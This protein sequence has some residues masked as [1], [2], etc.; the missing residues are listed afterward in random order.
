MIFE[1]LKENDKAHNMLCNAR[2]KASQ[3]MKEEIKQ[4]G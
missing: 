1:R 3:K 2:E 4:C